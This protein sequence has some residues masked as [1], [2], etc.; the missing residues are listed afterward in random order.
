V[1]KS[2]REIVRMVESRLVG[3][4]SSSEFAIAFAKRR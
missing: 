4:H 1:I 3:G 2:R